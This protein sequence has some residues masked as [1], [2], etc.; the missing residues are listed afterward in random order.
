MEGNGNYHENGTSSQIK[1]RYLATAA[2]HVLMRR[3]DTV[4]SWGSS[5]HGVLGNGPTGSRFGTPSVVSHFAA[6]NIKYDFQMFPSLNIW[7]LKLN[8]NIDRVISVA[9][10]KSHSL[11][12]TDNGLYTW[13][14]SKHGQLGLGRHNVAEQ[15]PVLVGRDE[16]NEMIH[17]N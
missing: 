2:T 4:V 8:C 16:M 11:A 17:P 15:R 6:L 5:S 12:L 14:S 3:K 10:G 1:G 7:R 9:C 13:G